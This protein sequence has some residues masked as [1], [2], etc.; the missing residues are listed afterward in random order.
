M[1]LPMASGLEERGEAC[2]LDGVV[3]FPVGVYVAE[4]ARYPPEGGYAGHY[5]EGEESNEGVVA[6]GY[7]PTIWPPR[8]AVSLIS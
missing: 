8:V 4:V 2:A 6:H 5:D 3:G 1:S 7:V